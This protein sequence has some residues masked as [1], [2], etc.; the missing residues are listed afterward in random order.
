[1]EPITKL[2]DR[3][4]K[5]QKASEGLNE[6]AASAPPAREEKQVIEL[7]ASQHPEIHLQLR[8]AHS[9]SYDWKKQFKLT[10]TRPQI[11]TERPSQLT[12]L[13][14]KIQKLCDENVFVSFTQSEALLGQSAKILNSIKKRS[15]FWKK[16]L[17]KAE[18]LHVSADKNKIYLG[19][20][21]LQPVS[22]IK[23]SLKSTM[24]DEYTSGANLLK[25][26]NMKG[27]DDW[28]EITIE[29]NAIYEE[30]GAGEANL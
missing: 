28:M 11:T 7:K 17:S 29:I 4:E 6:V 9:K 24:E 13:E 22:S 16:L 19:M 12:E 20:R 26:Y 25:T 14:W 5:L 8:N 3:F 1:M 21:Y 15:Q 10:C 30:K 27:Q 18:H 2:I 23:N